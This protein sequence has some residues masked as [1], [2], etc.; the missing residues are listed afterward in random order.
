MFLNISDTSTPSK[1]SSDDDKIPSKP[2]LNLVVA[3]SA[4]KKPKNKMTLATQIWKTI[5]IVPVD[6]D[7][8][9]L[10][11]FVLTCDGRLKRNLGCL[12]HHLVED[13]QGWWI[14]CV[15]RWHAHQ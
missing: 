12:R 9:S 3:T 8:D 15:S 1:C 2:K 4:L 10:S 14:C 13:A 6:T 11:A 5:H 7:E